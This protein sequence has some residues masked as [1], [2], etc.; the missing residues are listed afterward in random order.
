VNLI[1]CV[2]SFL[3]SIIHEAPITVCLDHLLLGGE[4]FASR[5]HREIST[6]L[7][8]ERVTNFYGPTETT[9]DAIGYSL[10]GA[11]GDLQIPIGKP[12]PNY[13]V[14]VLDGSLQPVP[15]GVPGEL[16]IAGAASARG[17]L[18]RPA[19]KRRALRG[20]SQ[21]AAGSAH[22]PYRRPGAVARRGGP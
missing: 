16:Y 20:R 11:D 18:K 13:R 5:L 21:R 1:N 3:T 9:I 15:V 7:N 8:I 17:Y 19:L 6:Y 12:L 4:V 22:V 14:Y 2:P 10:A